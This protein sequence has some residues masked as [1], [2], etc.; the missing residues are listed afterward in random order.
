MTNLS[1][2]F[3]QVRARLWLDKAT[4]TSHASESTEPALDTGWPKPWFLNLDT[5]DVFD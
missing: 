4:W 5:T 2:L 1:E 3:Q